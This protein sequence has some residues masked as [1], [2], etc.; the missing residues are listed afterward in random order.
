MQDEFIDEEI[1][2]EPYEGEPDFLGP[3][4]SENGQQDED[5]SADVVLGLMA[6]AKQPVG[7]WRDALDWYNRN[8]TTKQIG[9]N[10]DNMCLKV[11]RT[12][13]GIPSV[14]P[15]AKTAQDATPVEHRVKSV[16]EL[17][18]GMVLYYDHPA[19]SNRFG[20][21]VTM[22]GRVKRGN[23]DAL[24]DIL[25]ET[26]SVKSGELVVVRGDYFPRYWGDPFQFGATWLNGVELDIPEKKSKIE[27]FHDS[28]PTFDLKKLEKAGE[29]RPKAKWTLKAIQT[30]VNLLPDSPKLVRVR[31][32]KDKVRGEKVIDLRLLDKAVENGR[33]GRVKRVRDEIRRLIDALPD[34]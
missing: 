34:E 3:Q 21:V 29:H 19:D 23:P 9:F 5:G 12:A 7:T 4:G 22:V 18:R 11:C 28:G 16:R 6:R 1:D 27:K 13:R 25:V 10:P 2:I 33:V 30:Q 17:R 8:Q 20:H 15:S 26:N 24:S 32:F 31:E 14:Y